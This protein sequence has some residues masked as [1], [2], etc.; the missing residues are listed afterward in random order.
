MLCISMG[1][2]G[3]GIQEICGGAIAVGNL[4]LHEDTPCDQALQGPSR[5]REPDPSEEGDRPHREAESVLASPKRHRED[6]LQEHLAISAFC[7]S[8]PFEARVFP[9]L[10]ERRARSTSGLACHGTRESGEPFIGDGIVSGLLETLIPDHMKEFQDL[11]FVVVDAAKPSRKPL[12]VLMP[13]SHRYVLWKPVRDPA[14]VA[15]RT[16]CATAIG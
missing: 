11:V 9:A 4:K 6:R 2:V 5:A 12:K 15:P 16:W 1:Q 3:W 13:G 14:A 8:L 10:I 7:A